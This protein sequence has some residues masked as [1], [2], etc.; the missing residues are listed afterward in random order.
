[1]LILYVPV[2][3]NNYSVMSGLFSVFLGLTSTKQSIKCLAPGH[4]TVPLVRLK[5]VTLDLK[6]NILLLSHCTPWSSWY[7]S[8]EPQHEI[9]KNVVYATS[10]DSDKPAHMRSLIRAFASRLNIQL[11]TEHLFEFLSL[12]GGCTVLSE[13]TLVKMPHGNHMSLLIYVSTNWSRSCM[14]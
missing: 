6:S 10:K 7:K 9:S 11:L 1:M 8:Y 3:V 14:E 13:S 2:Q 4:N 5:P 12:K